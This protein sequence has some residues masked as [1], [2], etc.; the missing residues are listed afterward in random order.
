MLRSLGA[1]AAAA[2]FL[3]GRLAA[4]E[5]ATA[6]AEGRNPKEVAKD[7]DFWFSVRRSYDISPEFVHLESGWY[8]AVSRDVLDAHLDNARALNRITSFYL[9][10]RYD[11][12]KDGMKQAVADLAGV[13]PEEMALCRNTTE[14]LNTVILGLDTRP[15]DEF[16]WCEREY[17]S[18]KDALEQSAERY[19]T[20]NRIVDVPLVPRSDS[21]VVEAYERALT[22]R[23]RAILISHMVYLTGQVLPVRKVADMAHARGVEVIVDAAH[24]FAHLDYRLPELGADYLGTSLHKW[25]GAPLGMGLLYVKKENI[26]KVWP[27]MADR[28]F[29]KDDIRKFEHLGTRPVHAEKTLLA[30]IRFHRTLGAKRKEERLRYLKSYWVARVRELERVTINTPLS[31][32]GSCGIANVAIEG[33]TPTEVADR[34][35]DEHRVFTVAVEQGVRVSPNLFNGLEDLDALVEGIRAL[36]A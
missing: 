9:R 11:D 1:G 20:V 27:L 35:F 32:E 7:E 8:S 16:V 30:S 10:R 31:D 22:D 15:G 21:E 24:S 13:P 18:M 33:L 25:L 19:G 17:P 29:P 28:I 36:A 5:A 34:L 12:E 2:A 4:V 23:T 6:R 3:P 26:P 14:A